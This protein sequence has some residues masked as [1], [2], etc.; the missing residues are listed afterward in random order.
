MAHEL[1]FEQI[2]ESKRVFDSFKNQ[3]EKSMDEAKITINAVLPALLELKF[4]IGR[5]EVN[6]MCNNMNLGKDID[7]PTFLRLAAIKFK[8]EEFTKELELAFKAFDKGGKGF[9]SYDELRSII[10]DY[11]PKM[12]LEQS[13]ELLK[14]MGRDLRGKFN[15]KEFVKE[16][17]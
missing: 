14:E 7:F 3:D 16:D 2:Q 1:T 8:Q 12:S 9:L 10:T 4:E 6:E 17:I 13:D 11:G 15:Y 5:E